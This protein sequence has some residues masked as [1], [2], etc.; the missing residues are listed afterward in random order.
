M[1][2]VVKA[3]MIFP[4][5][6]LWG[7]AMSA[8]QVE[9]NNKNNDWWTWEQDNGRFPPHQQSGLACN[10][11]Q[12]AE[13]DLD[14][15]AEMGVNAHRISI[16]WSRVE[17]EP[18]V[19]DQEALA[20]YRQ[21]LLAMHERG[22]EPMVALHHFT[23]PMWLVE[24]GDFGSE[25]VVDYFQRYTAKV[26]AELGDLVPKW[27]TFNEPMVY[28]FL[29]YLSDDFPAPAQRGL[30]PGFMAVNN[31]LR[32]HAAAYHTIKASRPDA[33]VGVAKNMPVFQGA[34]GS[35]QLSK[36]WA[37][38]VDWL[39]NESWL[40]SM[41]TGKVKRPFGSGVIKNLAGSYDFIGIN[42]YTRFYVKFPPGKEFI[43][44][45]WGEDAVVSDGDYGEV[46]PSGLYQA[47]KRVIKYNKPIY[48]TENGVPDQADSLR[49]SFLL[50]HLREVWRAISFCFPVMGYYHWSLVDNF[51]WDRGW[52]QRFGLIEMNPETQERMMRDSGRLYQEICQDY[53]VS[54]DMVARYAPSLLP[55]L[56]PGD[57]PK[58]VTK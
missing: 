57:M 21:I 53:A 3:K 54:S 38:R 41:E 37:K 15:A 50:T 22:I 27:L 46:Y 58:I 13:A 28:F 8:H 11:W 32:C 19:F 56:F 47:I 5:D 7:T 55:E 12:N 39:F 33:Q 44:R 36:W 45:D 14:R 29:R 40:E 23:N 17:P 51:E 24:K 52:T 6:F 20:R 49:P 1:S 2:F 9:G 48:I 42:Y 26:V 43:S 35:G 18:S 30:R 34:P 25:I 4:P 31:M 10:W 16:E